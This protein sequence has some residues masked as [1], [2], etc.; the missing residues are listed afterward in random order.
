MAE[1]KE[2]FAP[3]A[4]TTNVLSVIRRFRDKGLPWPLTISSIQRIGI[5]GPNAGRTI[6][7]LNFLG[8][9]NDQGEKGS[10]AEK[11]A[12]VPELNYTQ[13]LGDILRE[14]YKDVF[15]ILDPANATETELN[16]A[17]RH[18]EPSRQRSRMVALFIGLCREAQIIA[19]E[20]PTVKTRKLSQLL[21][22][23]TFQ[24]N[25]D[26]PR[27]YSGFKPSYWYG[28]IEKLLENLPD[29]NVR[30]WKSA[31][32]ERWFTALSALLDLL[33]EVKDE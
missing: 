7:A 31:E 2:N 30:S 17:F 14:A 9:V 25:K 16:D 8:L 21:V 22:S 10:E 15:A 11:L 6:K 29:P 23:E 20:P 18:F 28:Q 24:A 27:K 1:Q 33:I 5:S 13:L 32:K 19:G 26:E 12:K 4:A 3:Y